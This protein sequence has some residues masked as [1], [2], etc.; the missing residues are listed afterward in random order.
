MATAIPAEPP[1]RTASRRRRGRPTGRGEVTVPRAVAAD[2]ERQ[3]DELLG[4]SLI[5][6]S[7]SGVYS[8]VALD[9]KMRDERK[10]MPVLAES[11]ASNEMLE[12]LIE[13]QVEDL[14]DAAGLTAMEEI[15]YRLYVSGLGRKRMSIALGIKRKTIDGRLESVKRKVRA[16]YEEGIYAG[17]YEV[18]LSEVN[19][20]AYR[21]R[22]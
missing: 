17:W 4:R 12:C 19:R 10:R 21:G 6:G 8:Q 5:A 1:S 2:L 3:A 15:V 11:G 22:R 18:Y 14:I 9:R 16:A 13:R 7:D 20:P